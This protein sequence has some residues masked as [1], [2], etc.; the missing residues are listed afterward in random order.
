[1]FSIQR[2]PTFKQKVTVNVKTDNGWREEHFIGIFKRLDGDH[3]KEIAN[4]PFPQAVDEVLVG[5]EMVD[6]ERKPVEFNPE[7]LAGFKCWS[8]ATRET[9]MAF[10][11]ANGGAKEKN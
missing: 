8:D 1:M 5:W 6:L 9:V 10:L 11:K 7:N 4:M 3:A 2:S